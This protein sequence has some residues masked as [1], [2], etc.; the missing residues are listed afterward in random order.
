MIEPVRLR[1]GS[2][3]C[4][5][6]HAVSSSE[7]CLYGRQLAV[8]SGIMSMHAYIAMY[9]ECKVNGC[10]ALRENDALSFRGEDHDV[11]IIE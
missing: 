7:N 11:I 5:Y 9:L 6:F 1:L 3:I 10:R 2:L 4:S 8:D